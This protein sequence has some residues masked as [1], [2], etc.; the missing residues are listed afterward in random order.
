MS[1]AHLDKFDSVKPAVIEWRNELP[2]STEFDDVYFSAEGGVKESDHVF[3]QGTELVH[4]WNTKP[5]QSFSIA[6]LGFG[7]GLNF[8]NTAHH[9]QQYL[10]ETD[11]QKKLS[12][13]NWLR[14][15]Y[16]SCK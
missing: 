14:I 5:Q 8:V 12:F 3:I 16:N 2:F 15:I 4:D 7:T 6:E 9:W 1:S 11:G 13:I 10:S